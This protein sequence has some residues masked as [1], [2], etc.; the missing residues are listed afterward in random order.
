MTAHIYPGGNST[1]QWFGKAYSGDTMPHPNV[2]V[3]HTTEGGSFPSYGGGGSAP[4]FTVKGKEV[5]QHF[6]ANHSAR[7]L[8]NKSGGVETNTLNVIQIELVGTCDKGGPGLYWPDAKDSDLAGLVDLIDWLTDTYD[9]PLVSTSKPWL[10]YPSS[11][12]SARGQRMSFAEWNSFKGICGHQHV[13]ENDHGDPGNFPIKRLIELVKAKKGKP[14]EPAPSKPAPSKPA[15][16][17]I[18]ALNSAV[19]PGARHAQ[20][21]D[22]QTFLVKAGYGPIPGAYTTYY[23]AE[24]QKAVAR[25]HNKNPHLKSAGVSYDPAIG[26]SGFKE[27]QREAGIK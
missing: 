6:Y 11:Y 23:G 24:T 13:P 2:I 16:S 25:F 4:T 27:L 20:V 18:V 17:K 15:P 5:H 19:K 1:V 10:S 14:S 12:G 21:K 9:V 22:L 8:V 7:A 26:K 3:L